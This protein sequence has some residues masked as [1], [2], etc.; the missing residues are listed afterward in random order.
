[1]INTTIEETIKTT[2][3]KQS[4]FSFKAVIIE[5]GDNYGLNDCLTHEE[6]RPLVEFYDTRYDQFVS[7][8]YVKTI[9]EVDSGLNLH[10]GV[11]DWTIDKTGMDFVKDWLKNNI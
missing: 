1:M 5:K 3:V 8:Y 10:G 4:D 2:N 9:L 7:R 11:E 6:V